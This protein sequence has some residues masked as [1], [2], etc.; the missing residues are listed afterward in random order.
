MVFSLILFV[1]ICLIFVVDIQPVILPVFKML[2]KFT[3]CWFVWSLAFW[4]LDVKPL[5]DALSYVGKNSLG[6]YWLNGFALVAARTAIFVLLNVESSVAIAVG[7]FATCVV[8]ETIAVMIV[9]KIP[10]VGNLIGV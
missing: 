2:T 1:P 6:Y 8:I 10:Y 5:S 4:I 9:M 7:V 3:G